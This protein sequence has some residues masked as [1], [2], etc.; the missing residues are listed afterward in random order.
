MARFAL[1]A[2]WIRRIFNPS[3]I[4]ATRQPYA[5]SDDVQLTHRYLAGGQVAHPSLWVRREDGVANPGPGNRV[6]IIAPVSYVGDV[7]EMWRI[8]FI[9]LQIAGTPSSDF[10]FNLEVTYPPSGDIITIAEKILI[11]NGEVQEVPI[12]P[13]QR[14]V[15]GSESQQ[16]THQSY[17]GPLMLPG[18]PVDLGGSVNLQILQLSAQVASTEVLNFGYYVLRN[19]IGVAHEL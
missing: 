19:Q 9:G 13:L 17:G 18:Y 8:F 6:T 10:T 4:P 5:V 7:P 15:T 12:W 11:G 14:A 1:D 3:G 2:P 16:A